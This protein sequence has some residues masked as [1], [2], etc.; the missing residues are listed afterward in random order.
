MND[1]KY[2]YWKTQRDNRSIYFLKV[3]LPTCLFL[4]LAIDRLWVSEDAYITFRSVQ[5][6]WLGNGPVFNPGI[7]V[8]SFSHPLWFMILSFVG[9]A[10]FQILPWASAILGVVFATL[11][12]FLTALVSYTRIRKTP[13]SLP[14]GLCTILALPP[15][16]D[17]ASS[18]LETGLTLCWLGGVIFIL[19]RIYTNLSSHQLYNLFI[20]GLGPLIR[21]DL[22]LFAGS[23]LGL[24]L[25]YLHKHGYPLRHI[26]N[27]IGIFCIPAGLWQIFRMG[28]YATLVPNTYLAKEAA[29]TNWSQGFQ[30]FRD[31]YVHYHLVE[32]FAIGIILFIAYIRRTTRDEK[33]ANLATNEQ[34]LSTLL[35]LQGALYTILV[36]RVG[37]DFM[38]ARVLL[39]GIFCLAA[40]LFYIPLP[41]YPSLQR[42]LLALLIVWGV[43]NAL[44][45][46]HSGGNQINR[47]GIADERQWYVHRTKVTRPISL[48]DYSSMSF[49]KFGQYFQKLAEKKGVKA[50]LWAH[51]GLT[52]AAMNPS[53][54]TLIDSLGLNDYINARLTTN[55]R[56]RSG[57]EKISRPAWFL[58]RYRN[59]PHLVPTN[60]LHREF[61]K[62]ESPIAI[63][64]AEK[65]LAAPPLQELT[66]AI[67]TPLTPRLFIANLFNAFRLTFL[68]IPN[69]PE[70]AYIVFTAP[71]PPVQTII[72]R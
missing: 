65:V 36:I 67:T 1:N 59:V 29:S 61:I 31:T 37:G 23:F 5:N 28:Y 20:I 45:T 57:H 43:R 58:A 27:A 40:A 53:D 42:V 10:G 8:E 24:Y 26:A 66:T 51:I 69:D 13:Y 47:Y 3:I 39:P 12:F 46:Q 34:I 19:N 48:K 56:G 9:I 17:F 41:N 64:Y 60:Q 30:Y 32:I 21:L 68:R 16:W 52:S 55:K 63:Q 70:Q 49:Y 38:H 4:L 71:E 22:I 50:V 7:R 25:L 2:H 11:G 72:S 35:L 15:F 54:I 14:L 33:E 44:F 18:G 6:L 62:Q